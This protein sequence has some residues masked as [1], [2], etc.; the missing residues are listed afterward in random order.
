MI[1]VFRLL[2]E[3]GLN[4]LDEL[5]NSLLLVG[6]A[7]NDTDLSIAHNAERKHA[8]KALRINSALILFNLDG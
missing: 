7:R 3:A 2:G 6:A 8:E 1:S 4:K 5:I